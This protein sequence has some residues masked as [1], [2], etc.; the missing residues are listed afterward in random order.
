MTIPRRGERAVVEAGAGRPLSPPSPVHCDVDVGLG[1]GGAE[2]GEAPADDA[3]AVV[4]V[5]IA[6]G[7][8]AGSAGVA[9]GRVPPHKS[10][11]ETVTRA[12]QYSQIASIDLP[13]GRVPNC[14]GPAVETGRRTRAVMGSETV[15]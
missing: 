7:A 14:H 9:D 5:P 11:T 13:V 2:A 1:G 12:P 6:K 4:L 15:H 8:G 3:D 10:Q